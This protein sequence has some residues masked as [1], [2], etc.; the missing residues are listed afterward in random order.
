MSQYVCLIDSAIQRGLNILSCEDVS[1][2][3]GD[4]RINSPKYVKNDS[5]AKILLKYMSSYLLTNSSVCL[6][7]L[8]LNSILLLL[9]LT[10][11]ITG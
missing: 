10:H 6:L 11:S 5:Q 1:V 3:V 8:C 4:G 2:S 7:F 9:S